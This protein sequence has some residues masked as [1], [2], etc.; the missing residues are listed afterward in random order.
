MLL[1]TPSL[2]KV[3]K[4]ANVGFFS[5]VSSR[6][7]NDSTTLVVQGHVYSIYSVDIKKKRIEIAIIIIIVII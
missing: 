2:F 5:P 3:D 6:L 7:K 1:C 4:A